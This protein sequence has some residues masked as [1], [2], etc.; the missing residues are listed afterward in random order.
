MTV[1]NYFPR[2]EDLV[3]DRAEV[4]IRSLADAAAARPA[5]A[6]SRRSAV[7]T[8][9][10]SPRATLPSARAR[11]LRKRCGASSGGCLTWCT[12]SSSPTGGHNQNVRITYDPAADAAYIYLTGDPLRPGR[13]TIHALTPPGTSGFIALDWKGHHLVGIEILDAS[14]RL[15]HDLLEEA[16]IS[17]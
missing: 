16:E 5:R 3:F 12:G 10:G 11:P 17:D 15:H 8:P 13:T 4:T 6:C 1:T 9:S 7:T 2:K 14:A